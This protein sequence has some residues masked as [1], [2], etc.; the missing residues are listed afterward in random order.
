MDERPVFVE[1]G[2][3]VPCEGAQPTGLI[4]TDRC[5][6]G[7]EGKLYQ[8]RAWAAAVAADKAAWDGRSW[9][10]KTFGMRPKGYPAAVASVSVLG[11][12]AAIFGFD[13]F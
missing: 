13:L 7:Y 2:F 12:A 11:S 8:T 3:V 6:C 5:A 4:V 1:A 9:L 10:R